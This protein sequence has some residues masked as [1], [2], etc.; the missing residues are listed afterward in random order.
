MNL[1]EQCTPMQPNAVRKYLAI[2][3][4]PCN[5]LLNE[6]WVGQC[7]VDSSIHAHAATH[8]QAGQDRRC[9]IISGLR[10][11]TRAA[12]FQAEHHSSCAVLSF[13]FLARV[14][15]DTGLLR[16]TPLPAPGCWHSML[17]HRVVLT[18]GKSNRFRFC[19]ALRIIMDRTIRVVNALPL[20]ASHLLQ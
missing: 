16:M 10:R 1:L 3:K 6:I 18:S 14:A 2:R 8:L 12:L 5:P 20:L 11:F 17:P 19:E 9:P 7:P 15:G 4:T 13:P